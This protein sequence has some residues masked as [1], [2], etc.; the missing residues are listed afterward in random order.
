[1]DM[2]NKVPRGV[3]NVAEDRSSFYENF[4]RLAKMA[5]NVLEQLNETL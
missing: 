5:Q 4:I 2:H 3:V 1:M